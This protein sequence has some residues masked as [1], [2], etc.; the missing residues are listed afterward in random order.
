VASSHY[1]VFTARLP[2]AGPK[3]VKVAGM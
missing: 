2:A 1:R 3:V